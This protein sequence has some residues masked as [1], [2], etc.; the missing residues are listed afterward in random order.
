MQL[1]QN[2]GC[3]EI[4]C[5]FENDENKFEQNFISCSLKQDFSVSIVIF[6]I[7]FPIPG[8]CTVTIGSLRFDKESPLFKLPNIKDSS[9]FILL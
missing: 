7:E 8:S 6:V 3:N 9:I 2:L 4:V 5:R 1:N